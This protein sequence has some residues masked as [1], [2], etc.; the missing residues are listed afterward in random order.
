MKILITGTIG[1]GKTTLISEFEKDGFTVVHEQARRL[2]MEE[3]KKESAVLP[4]TNPL[5]FQ[6][7]LLDRHIQSELLWQEYEDVV[8]FDT[9]FLDSLTFI[10]MEDPTLTPNEYVR[11]A[12]FLNYDL[13]FVLQPLADYVNDP[14]RPQSHEYAKK[15]HQMKFTV[16]QD[17]FKFRVVSVPDCGVENR[18][19]FIR[20]QIALHQKKVIAKR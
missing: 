14:Q 1:S 10:R 20:Q 12:R 16:W 7:Q 11:A 4:W 6:T 15:L 8:F 13:V 3:Q 5:A 19:E 9:G 18:K 17:E 2:I